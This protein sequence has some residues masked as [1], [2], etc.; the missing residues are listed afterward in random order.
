[1]TTAAALMASPGRRS[2]DPAPAR[3]RLGFRDGD[4]G[5]HSS[6]TMMLA[7]LRALLDASTV[8]LA[9]LA[10]A[11]SRRGL[12]DFR[13]VGDVVEL[14]FPALLNPDE[15]ENAGVGQT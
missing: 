3:K 4:R 10:R 6:R 13:Q 9:E 8:E 15:E 2:L 12:C 1:M 5:V 7:E 14:R 11:A